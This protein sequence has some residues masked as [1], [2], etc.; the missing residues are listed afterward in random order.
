R[1]ASTA[2][3]FRS[4]HR[5]IV[6]SY[7]AVSLAVPERIRYRYHLDGF[8]R[9]WSAPSTERTAMYT[10]LAPGHYVFRVIAS[11]S[12]GQWN[13]AAQTLALDL[14]PALWQTIWFRVAALLV[15]AAAMWAVYRAR[16]AQLSRQLNVRFEERLAERNRI[17]QELHDTLLQGFLS[18]SMHLHVATSRVPDDSPA[19]PQLS[20]VLDLIGRVIDEGRNAIHG[21]RAPGSGVNDLE[22][23]L[24][25]VA[26]DLGIGEATRFR[27]IA[28]GRAQAVHPMVRDEVYRIGREALANAVR[29]AH[30]RTIEI[31][32]RY[33]P[34][35]LVLIV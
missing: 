24:T 28:D 7:G 1:P 32:L 4:G 17:A 29:H 8:D 9:E 6:F 20:Y 31:E 27:V 33:Q 14:L 18:A 35:Q 30:A 16:V 13:G 3:E 25:G 26:R 12:S 22:I 21:L 15:A 5:R 19:R 2:M 11:D 23:A 10:N 34:D